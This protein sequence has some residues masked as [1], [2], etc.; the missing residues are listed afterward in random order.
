MENKP[1]TNERNAYAS[2]AGRKSM[3][4]ILMMILFSI[5][6]S[7][8]FFGI[9]LGMVIYF[10]KATYRKKQ[11]KYIATIKRAQERLRK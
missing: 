3:R 9:G 6:F 1:N 11:K 5:V 10:A 8:T 7:I 4:L 2:R